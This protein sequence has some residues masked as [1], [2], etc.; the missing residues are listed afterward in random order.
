M[1]GDA[2]KVPIIYDNDAGG[3]IDD[4]WT[5]AFILSHPKL[6]LKAVT[7][8][9]SKVQVRARLCAKVLRLF[10]RDDIP[11][12]AGIRVPEMFIKQGHDPKL[13]KRTITQ[14]GL[15]TA[16]DPE[17]DRTYPEDAVD[18]LLD[19]FDKTPQP[20]GIVATGPWSN[21]GAL[22]ERATDKQKRN[23]RF[24]SLMGGETH[25]L[26]REGNA[27]NDPEAAKAIFD[28]GLPVFLGTWN[29]TRQFAFTIEEAKA[30]LEHATDPIRKLLYDGLIAWWEQV[31]ADSYKSGPV[32]YDV[33]PVF[34][35]VGLDPR[36][37][38]IKADEIGVEL[39]GPRTRG[40]T[41]IGAGPHHSVIEVSAPTAA[42][43][44]LDHTEGKI[45]V[46]H[47]IDVD[48]LKAEFVDRL[49]KQS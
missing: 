16:D 46:S 15:V 7:T 33:I 18:F 42:P 21:I 45:L 41:Y 19:F 36:I 1:T 39:E 4:L 20:V 30:H 6:D 17:H 26:H 12:H 29:V 10:G 22:V 43:C 23:I 3:D 49:F 9:A 47:R 13:Y 11:V 32:L 48:A 5:L 40:L 31:G 24:I 37:E 27:A 2:A 44:D 8:V 25:V 38:C 28:S 35:A 14:G 34:Q